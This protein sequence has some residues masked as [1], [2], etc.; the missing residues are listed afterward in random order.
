MKSLL[1]SINEHLVNEENQLTGDE[2]AE[3]WDIIGGFIEE[4]KY[5]ELKKYFRGMPNLKG[6]AKKLVM[7]GIAHVGAW[8]RGAAASVADDDPEGYDYDGEFIDLIITG[9]D[10]GEWREII[11]DMWNDDD[12]ERIARKMT[13]DGDS[14]GADIVRWFEGEFC[15]EFF[16]N[17]IEALRKK[18]LHESVRCGSVIESLHQIDEARQIEYRVAFLGPKD[19]EGLTFGV[20]ILVDK[21]N[22]KAF[23]QFLNQEEGN[24]FE[25]AEGGNVEY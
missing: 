15:P 8:V 5:P 13:G 12:Y 24:I 3:Y 17:W 25:H 20:D 2:F 21:E 18:V 19:S 9:R 22:Q 1:K 16:A 23:E 11:D 7:A 6:D 4:I 10:P 14:E